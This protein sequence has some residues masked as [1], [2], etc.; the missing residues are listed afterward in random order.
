VLAAGVPLGSAE[1]RAVPDDQLLT[2]V[3]PDG[4]FSVLS[5]GALPRAIRISAPDFASRTVNIQHPSSDVELGDIALDR[6]ARVQVRVSGCRTGCQ[7]SAE[8]LPQTNVSTSP[9]QPLE[10]R[11]PMSVAVRQTDATDTAVAS[12]AH[13]PPGDYFVVIS[14]HKRRRLLEVCCRPLSADE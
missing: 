13:V 5:E 11:T 14:V 12:F 3:T 4:R 7:V 9:N 1:V 6:G 8:L 10:A 2:R